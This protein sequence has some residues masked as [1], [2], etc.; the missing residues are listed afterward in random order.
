MKKL[1]ILTA[2]ALFLV[3][4]ITANVPVGSPISPPVQEIRIT[5]DGADVKKDKDKIQKIMAV[6]CHELEL[7]GNCYTFKDKAYISLTSINSY[8]AQELWNDFKIL[9][10]MENIKELVIYMS[11]PGGQAFEGMGITDEL[12]LFKERGIPITVEG[13]G[14]IAS[15]A[16]PVYLMAD[17][18][19]AS[20]Y[21]I[22]M[23]HPAKLW[24]WGIFAEGLDDLQSQATMINLLNSNYA[25][26]VA[27]RSN[28]SKEEVLEML[29]KDNWFTAEEALKLGFVDEIK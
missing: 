24:K 21:T 8:R 18:R 19:I 12:R 2:I 23:I 4:C 25:E 1:F 13:R 27:A 17:K 7:S 9:S 6:S 22:F 16:I 26:S 5:V 20:R 28:V 29:K 15:A 10:E 11:N 14:L 3:G